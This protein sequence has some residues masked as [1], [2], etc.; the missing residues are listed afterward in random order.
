M[1]LD[2]RGLLRQ[3]LKLKET[4]LSVLTLSLPT[5]KFS[6]FCGHD[7]LDSLQVSTSTFRERAIRGNFFFFFFTSFQLIS[8]AINY[9]CPSLILFFINSTG[10]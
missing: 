6:I 7:L 4:D 9:F 5:I 2:R 10:L 8:A 1:D 3:T